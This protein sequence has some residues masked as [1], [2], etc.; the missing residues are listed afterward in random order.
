ME[1]DS[2][3]PANLKHSR[4]R[5]QMFRALAETVPAAVMILRDK[6]VLYANPAA[7]RLLGYSREELY[8]R[9]S[10]VIVHPE[11]RELIRARTQARMRGENVP[12]R[13][14]IQVVS[15]QGAVRWVD[16]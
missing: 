15:K 11:H 9:D 7:E 3:T 10:Y 5:E 12:S 8:V 14:T 16:L 13:Y 6:R 4:P 1:I 2:T